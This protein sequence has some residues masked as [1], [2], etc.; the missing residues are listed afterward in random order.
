MVK[1]KRVTPIEE[2]E[3][4]AERLYNYNPLIQTKLDFDKSYD[5]YMGG[6]IR[7]NTFKD[8]TWEVMT[9][10]F[11]KEGDIPNKP[12]KN[13]KYP[14]KKPKKYEENYLANVWDNKNKHYKVQYVRKVTDKKG[15]ERYKKGRY[16]VQVDKV[17]YVG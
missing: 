2:F 12:K 11:I 7:G 17:K 9:S 16:Y 3:R 6:M 1:K 13:Q 15:V 5:D 4:F 14:Q 8:K 10:K